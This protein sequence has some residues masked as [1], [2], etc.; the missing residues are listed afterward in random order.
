MNGTDR[1]YEDILRGAGIAPTAIRLLVYAAIAG[2][3]V[4]FS[5]NEL[6]NLLDTVDRSSIF[7]ALTAFA[8]HGLLHAIDDGN[9]HRKYCLCASHS[10][11]R[12]VHFTC[13]LCG[14]T[15]CLDRGEI[16]A[17]TLPDGFAGEQINY[18]VTGVCPK[19]GGKSAST[20]N[21]KK[22]I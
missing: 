22:R 11:C 17:V 18:S 7:R 20:L 19:C 13:R 6:E 5:V 14:R 15:Y 10:R 2:R 12:H 9:G 1:K 4:A 8:E 16:P 3:H 21:P